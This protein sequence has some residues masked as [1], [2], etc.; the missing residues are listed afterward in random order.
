MP[1]YIGPVDYGEIQGHKFQLD[2]GSE[3]TATNPAHIAALGGLPPQAPMPSDSFDPMAGAT[4]NLDAQSFYGSQQPPEQVDA[5]QFYQQPPEPP[6]SEDPSALMSQ[7]PQESSFENPTPAGMDEMPAQQPQQQAQPE[8]SLNPYQLAALQTPQYGYSAPQAR[9][10]ADQTRKLKGDPEEKNMLASS[11]NE[12][13]EAR[14]ETAAKREQV[15][16]AILEQ[17]FQERVIG[18]ANRQE[19]IQDKQ[20][21]LAEKKRLMDE[22]MAELDTK[23]REVKARSVD[24]TRWFKDRTPATT[25]LSILSVGAGAF[26][27][28]LTGGRNTALDMINRYVDADVA[29]Q[30]AELTAAKD[31]VDEERNAFARELAN[32]KDPAIVRE[33]LKLLQKEALSSQLQQRE[34]LQ[35]LAMLGINTEDIQQ[36]LQQELIQQRMALG[37]QY[38]QEVN[39]KWQEGRRGGAYALDPET[40]LKRMKANAAINFISMGYSPDQAQRLAERKF[41]A[42]QMGGVGG[43]VAK[44]V[45][46]YGKELQQANLPATE[47][48]ISDMRS[49]L[50]SMEREGVAEIPTPETRNVASRA[51]RSVEQG[52]RGERPSL[53]DSD[54]EVKLLGQFAELRNKAKNMLYGAAVSEQENKGF[55]EQLRGVNTVD[56]MRRWVE[57]VE[58][59]A[60]AKKGAIAAGHSPQAVQ[61]YEKQNAQYQNRSTDNDVGYREE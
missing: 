12:L 25:L 39:Q 22:R 24:H 55:L 56:G 10:F 57:Q 43:A 26:G 41:E 59:A 52:I 13:A 61:V 2:D 32:G 40:R 6:M 18:N 36:Q 37:A 34:T 29:N 9:G 51:F 15:Q 23:A 14:M 30:E 47:A 45:Q 21:E 46:Q 35:S 33:E 60:R 20:I 58:R 50:D 44:D 42:E 11:M 4:A 28:S 49:I 8:V 16:R 31:T 5:G 54:S 1:N 38:S 48:Q 19:Q 7:A 3:F 53:L 27:A 17:D